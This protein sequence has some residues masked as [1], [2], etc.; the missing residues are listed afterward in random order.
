MTL[1]DSP[2]AFLIAFCWH[3]CSLNCTVTFGGLI[4][5]RRMMS[6]IHRKTWLDQRF[7]GRNMTP[8]KKAKGITLNEDTTASRARATK[9]PMTGGKGKVKGKSPASPEASFD[10]GGIYATYLTT[11][12][13]KTS[14]KPVDYVVIRGKKVKCASEAINIVLDYPN[15]TNDECQYLI[16]TKTLDNMK[17]WLAPLISDGTPKWHEIGAPIEKKDLNIV[18]MFWFGFISNMIMPSQNE[19]IL[20]LAKTAYLC[21]IIYGTRLNLGMI[22]AQE[23]VIRAKQC[24]TS[25]PF[26]VLITELCR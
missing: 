17:K 10:S 8:R 22:I 25:L 4:H 5:A 12:E 13:S 26:P 7:A 14:F 21:C 18:A 1:D 3:P 9:L 19:S 23:M 11:S 24:H 16:R 2:K 15:D 6:A 20:R